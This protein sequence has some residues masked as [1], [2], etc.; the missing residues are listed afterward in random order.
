MKHDYFRKLGFV[1]DEEPESPIPVIT[2]EKDE[3]TKGEDE[4]YDDS[5]H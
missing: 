3:E 2:E 4:S 5:N 1:E